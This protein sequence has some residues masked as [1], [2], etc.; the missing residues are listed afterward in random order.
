MH[1]YSVYPD[2]EATAQ[3]AANC[4]AVEIQAVLERGRYCRIALPGGNTPGRCLELL[5]Q[6]ELPWERVHCYLGDERCLP[7]GDPDRNDTMIARRFWSQLVIPAGNIHVMAAELGAEA[8][9]AQYARELE[10]AGALDI[11]LLGMGE[12]GHT[13]SLFPGNPALDDPAS[14]VAVHDAP[15]PPPERVSLG[16]QSLRAATTRL[17]LVTG[18]GKAPA[19]QQVRAGAALPVNRIGDCHWFLDQAA[20]GGDRALSQ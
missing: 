17:L 18:A 20:D 6:R 16:V 5:A 11:V 7:A 1:R 2:A 13:A 15:K 12:D 19:M 3:A 9:A 14:V 8:A 4:L 10:A